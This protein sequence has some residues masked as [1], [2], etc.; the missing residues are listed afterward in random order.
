MTT[1]LSICVM[2][3]MLLATPAWAADAKAEIDF[4]TRASVGHL[5]AITESRLALDKAD[6]PKV[7]GFAQ[8]LIEDHQRDKTALEAAAD[9]SGATV[10]TALDGDH[11]ARVTALQGSSGAD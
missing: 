8:Q 6:G 7:E 9:G 11:L 1:I 5:F 2:G 3:L 10:A 4:V